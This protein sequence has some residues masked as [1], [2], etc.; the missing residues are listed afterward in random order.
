MKIVI[1]RREEDSESLVKA[2]KEAGLESLC[3][4]CLEITEPSDDYK[5]LDDVIRKNHLYDWVFFLSRNAADAFFSRLIEIGGQF[6]NLAPHLKIAVIGSSTASFIKNEVGFPVN[7]IPS[8]FNSDSFVK[9]FLENYSDPKPLPGTEKQKLLLV[10]AELDD[11]GFKERIEATE[12]FELDTA[13]AYKTKIPDSYD[14]EALK[15]FLDDDSSDRY[16]SFASSE[17]VRNFKEMTKTLDLSQYLKGIFLL[18]IGPKTSQA[19]KEEFSELDLSNIL[20]EAE[21]ATLESVLKCLY[22][23]R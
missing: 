17:T 10:R 8:K 12:E 19:I 18:S 6:F 5:S 21:E 3:F 2:S 9:E 20:L 16:I 13:L 14:L 7:F 4:P 15:A 1:T 23:R 11:D 22:A